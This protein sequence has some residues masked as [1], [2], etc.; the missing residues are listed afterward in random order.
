MHGTTLQRPVKRI[1]RTLTLGLC[2]ARLLAPLTGLAQES[3]PPRPERYFTDYSGKINRAQAN[4]LNEMLDGSAGGSPWPIV[5]V[6]FDHMEIE[7]DIA[8]H[9]RRVAQAWGIDEKDKISGVA[10]FVYIKDRQGYIQVRAPGCVGV[11][12]SGRPTKI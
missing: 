2:L 9:T 7:S 3:F 4:V 5:V 12:R 1:L 8:D 10:V 11:N 6:V